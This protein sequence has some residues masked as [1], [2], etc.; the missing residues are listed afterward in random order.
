MSELGTF[1]ISDQASLW[2]LNVV[3]HATVLTA[4]SLLV[5][6]LFR[7]AAAMRYWVLCFGLVLVLVSPVIS[8]MIQATGSSWLK[9]TIRPPVTEY[10]SRT[11]KPD[12]SI[13]SYDASQ[14]NQVVQGVLDDA[15][16]SQ[17]ITKHAINPIAAS[18]AENT[19]IAAVQ[20]APT[21]ELINP[22]MTTSRL[23]VLLRF[24]ILPLIL[25]WVMGAAFLLLRMSIGW[26]RMSQILRAARP[27]VDERLHNAFERACI[28]V[29]CRSGRRPHLV[30]SGAVS[31]PLAAGI[32]RSKI[33]LPESL[34]LRL[35][36]E[37][38]ADVLVHEVAHVI[39]RDHIVV[40]LQ[41]I[42]SAIYWPHPL[43]RKLNCELAKARE[44]VCD[45]F[46]LVATEA[47]TYSRVLLSLAQL[48]QHSSVK[49]GSVG[50]FTDQW[51][52]EHRI[53]G[54]LDTQRNRNTF[55][56][57]RGWLFVAATTAVLAAL[58]C[59]GTITVAT[60]QV[61][62]TPSPE[63]PH[64]ASGI[65]VSGVILKP[66]GSPAE[67]ATVRAAAPV[68]G[69]MRG[70]V[71]NDFET[72]INEVL[73]DK[74]GR[75][76]IS[77]ESEPYG[78][79]SAKGTK[80]N[81]VWKKTVISATLPGFAGQFTK[82]EDVEGVDSVTLQLVED[83]PIRG[84]VVDLEG[85]PISG[86]GIEVDYI[87]VTSN[88]SL[89]TWLKAARNDE[90]AWYDVKHF[91]RQ[92]EPRMLGVPETATTDSD[93]VFS[94]KGLGR[95]RY[96]HLHVHGNGIALD[97]FRVATRTMDLLTWNDVGPVVYGLDFTYAGRPS[98]S[99]NGTVTDAMTGMPLAG[100][101]V[102]VEMIS[103]KYTSGGWQ[104]PTKSNSLGQFQIDNMP[105]G[106]GNR[107]MFRPTDDQP[108][109]M[110]K[111]EVPDSDGMAPVVID[112]GLHR[113]IWIEGKVVDKQSREPVAG[114]RVHYLPF[115]TNRFANEL[116]EFDP[117]TVHG[118]QDRYQTDLDGNY[119]LV[120]LP[121]PA[122]VG[123][124]SFQPYVRGVGYDALTVP[125]DMHGAQTF[126]NPLVPRSNWPD[127][128]A[129]IDPSSETQKVGLDF[130]LD[131]GQ[132]IRVSV[133]DESNEW[134]TGGVL[135]G[136]GFGAQPIIIERA[137]VEVSNNVPSLAIVVHHAQ[138]G[139]GIVHHLTAAELSE[140]NLRLIAR[141]CATVSGRLV[142]E[143]EPFSGVTVTPYFVSGDSTR[144]L[145]AA[146][147]DE[148]GFFSA[149]LLPGCK[150]KLRMEGKRLGERLN[151][152]HV[153]EDIEIS[154]GEN[155]ELGTLVPSEGRTFT[156]MKDSN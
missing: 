37:S 42:V 66:D 33:V 155:I 104:L 58:T 19:N 59:I 89:D 50:F 108:Y 35:D 124:E 146:T 51:K 10:E 3:I 149:V 81:D 123:V 106:K 72:T 7:S 44:E 135:R 14:P 83:A 52:L 27:I 75:F 6:L 1:S 128:M 9:I 15:I 139:L 49:P 147:T 68:Y 45:N 117:V 12:I 94:I 134:L 48:L 125:K 116:P 5:A 54:L 16:A 25:I 67:G 130:E 87:F 76:Q 100:V 41:N 136:R 143:G 30:A 112:V 115:L 8:G 133:V 40:L 31:G 69:D 131:P 43:V 38:L 85:R 129:Q 21:P 62:D 20:V 29:G 93:G 96:I 17:P 71:G 114:V 151:S 150:Y 141:P 24:F 144:S 26:L 107:L 23:R 65:T 86:V 109:F 84:R 118:Q 137:P 22:A 36:P 60:A 92:I 70:I 148:N 32:L 111:L 119:R 80:W 61:E 63:V 79:L 4:V 91:P 46:V 120:G 110:R 99:V 57:K 153:D 121:G 90:L 11:T 74:L 140:G 138:R 47:P 127:A 156:R 154:P 56:S 105:K 82:Y 73:A 13:S 103:G 78:I 88:E 113:G 97:D 55:V 98:R 53:A 145:A 28:A 77:I 95:E 152:A 39:R 122:V 102:G 132:T 64:L 101:E 34:T 126:R 142:N 2:G 18:L